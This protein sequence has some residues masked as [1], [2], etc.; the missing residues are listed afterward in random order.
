MNIPRLI[1]GIS[2]QVSKN[3][4]IYRSIHVSAAYQRM[5]LSV[6]NCFAPSNL[7][8]PASSNT[9]LTRS[10]AK[11]KDKGKDKGK[12]SG[13]NVQANSAQMNAVV[14]YNKLKE[15]LVHAMQYFQEDFDKNL[16]IRS[17]TGE[18][19]SL[20]IQFDGKVYELQE[21]AQIIRK[22]PK[23]IL[24]NMTSFP[25]AIPDVL[26]AIQGSGL[27]LN[28]QQDGTTIIIPVPKVTKEHREH[29]VKNAKVLF[30]KHRDIIKNINITHVKEAK[31]KTGVSADLIH[32]VTSQ[33][34]TMTDKCLSDT[35]LIYT[36]KC[37]DLLGGKE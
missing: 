5:T 24:L 30:Y 6:T 26:K 10:Y 27:N 32:S 14:D 22:N 2:T 33:I 4:F 23:N 29:L 11:S 16:S 1:L 20:N 36:R 28:P 19:E 31:A 25:A 18:I 7:C 12:K 15:Q 3:A 35:K 17:T 13:G 34:S 9:Y 21:L 8:S 37:A